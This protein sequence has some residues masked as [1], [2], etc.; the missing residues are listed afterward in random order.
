MKWTCDRTQPPLSC[1]AEGQLPALNQKRI[2]LRWQTT[3]NAKFTISEFGTISALGN[4]D[5]L[6]S[7]KSTERARTETLER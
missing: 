5:R 7:C 4:R 6:M 1:S 3:Q 2:Q